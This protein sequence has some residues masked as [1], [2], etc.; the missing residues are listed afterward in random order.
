[1][2]TTR[3]AEHPITTN[4]TCEWCGRHGAKVWGVQPVGYRA[5]ILLCYACRVR[6]RHE[7]RDERAKLAAGMQ[8]ANCQKCGR[9]SKALYNEGTAAYPYWICGTCQHRAARRINTKE[10]Y[11]HGRR[12]Y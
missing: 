9:A 10:M 8:P 5:A 4:G 2:T 7:D 11:G 1:M 6:A 3:T 12:G